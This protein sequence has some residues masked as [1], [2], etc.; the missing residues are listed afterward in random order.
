[1]FLKSIAAALAAVIALSTSGCVITGA[2]LKMKCTLRAPTEVERC[3]V[4]P[5][6]IRGEKRG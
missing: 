6:L 5:K 4:Y 1:M 2:L 3:W